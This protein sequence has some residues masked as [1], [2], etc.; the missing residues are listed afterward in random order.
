MS[1]VISILQQYIT[2]NSLLAKPVD[3]TNLTGDLV[4]R[5]IKSTLRSDCSDFNST[6]D[7]IW[8]HLKP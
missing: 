7:Y 1:K 4:P 6:M 5:G 3:D 8:S 2:S